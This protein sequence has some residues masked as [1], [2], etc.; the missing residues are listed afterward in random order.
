MYILGISAYFHDSAAALVCNGEIIAAAQEERFSRIKNDPNFPIEAIR[1]C[2]REANITMAEVEEVVFFEKPFTKFDR[3]LQTIY[4]TTPRSYVSFLKAMPGWLKEKLLL[5]KTIKKNLKSVGDYDEKTLKILF[6]EHHLSHAASAYFPSGFSESAI[7][8]V[9]GVGEWATCTIAKGSGNA[10][11]M[12]RQMN[13]PHSIGLFY[14]A[15]TAYCGF[16]VNSD[17]YK[18]MGL[19]AYGNKSDDDFSRILDLLKS[20]VITIHTDGSVTLNQRYFSYRL[21]NRMFDKKRWSKLLGIEPRKPGSEITQHICNLGLAAQQIIEDVVMKL[22]KEAVALTGSKNLCLAGGVALNC[23][24][25][26]KIASSGIVERLFIQPAS[27]DAGGALG[28]ALAYYHIGKNKQL[29]NADAAGDNMKGS[30]LG[31]SYGNDQ[32]WAAAR[33]YS[34]SSTEHTDHELF[35][36]VT[37]GLQQGKVIG[38]HQGRMEYGPRALGNRSILAD[39]RVPGMQ[40]TI[41]LKVKFRE[42]FRPFAPIILKEALHSYFEKAYETPYMLMAF[43]IK[44]EFR[45]QYPGNFS[46]WS[47]TEKLNFERSIVPSVTHIDYTSRLQ[48][49]DDTV[50]PKLYRLLKCFF[51]ATDCPMLINTSFNRNNEP[52]I[53]TPTEALE[54]LQQT[55]I[56]WLVINNIIFKKDNS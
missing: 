21:G 51:E 3:I 12:L 56:D 55:D 23:L 48:S 29:R 27:G 35:E 22:A 6:S 9:D 53:N 50:N 20:E 5:K 26:G 30:L 7:L 34:F 36:E 10:I 18:L 2:L 42:G 4:E 13:F 37:L 31:P 32:I 28:A 45:N 41:N 54:C 38:W 15:V 47:M 17:E 40:R 19:A 1:Y 24:A 25:N 14:S 16:K 46:Q 49:V 11:K 52:I 43:P 39:P 33:R 44:E 8:T